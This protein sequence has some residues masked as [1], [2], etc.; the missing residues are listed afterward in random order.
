MTTN[1]SVLTP[2]QVKEVNALIDAAK[3]GIVSS[4][5]TVV[6]NSQTNIINEAKADIEKAI[7]SNQRVMLATVQDSSSK[8]KDSSGKEKVWEIFKDLLPVLATAVLG[9]L[10]WW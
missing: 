1:Q 6:Q 7:A 2:E 8:K 5:T 4:V 3:T 10:V 9:F